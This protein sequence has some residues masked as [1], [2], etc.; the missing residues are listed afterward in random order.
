[1]PASMSFLSGSW[2]IPIRQ[3]SGKGLKL[4][5]T[6]EPTTTEE[7]EDD[8]EEAAASEDGEEEESGPD[9]AQCSMLPDL[10]QEDEKPNIEQNMSANFNFTPDFTNQGNAWWD[11]NT[12]ANYGW[13]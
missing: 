2:D 1:L 7:E 13:V 12:A 4:E 10:G 8:D 5:E 6:F 3:I 11:T 9:Q